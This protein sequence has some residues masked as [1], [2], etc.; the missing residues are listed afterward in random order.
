VPAELL[1]VTIAPTTAAVAGTL[2]HLI[3]VLQ[4]RGAAGRTAT[5]Q[6]PSVVELEVMLTARQTGAA[7]AEACSEWLGIGQR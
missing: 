2:Q 7:E 5:A 6:R 1:A 4:A 3:G